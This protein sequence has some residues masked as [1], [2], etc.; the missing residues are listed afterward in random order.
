MVAAAQRYLYGSGRI[1]SLG[2]RDVQK[3]N[4]L[5]L[6]LGEGSQT[7]GD[8]LHYYDLPLTD[9]QLVHHLLCV[10]VCFNY[11]AMPYRCHK[12]IGTPLIRHPRSKNPRIFGMPVPIFLGKF[13]P[14]FD[15]PP[16]IWHPATSDS[17]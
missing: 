3:V 16:E 2:V 9:I 7:E 14:T 8:I 15:L 11:P 5:G 12:K 6:E 17:D 10:C 1:H 13:D 4:G